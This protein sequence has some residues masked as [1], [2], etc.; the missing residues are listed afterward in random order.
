MN[1]KF[2]AKFGHIFIIC[3]SGKSAQ[4]MLAALKDRCA[5]VPKCTQAF[6]KRGPLHLPAGY[7]HL[8]RHTMRVLQGGWCPA[9]NAL[10]R[11]R[12]TAGAGMGMSHMLSW[13]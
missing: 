11:K 1:Q 10:H 2:E 8:D 12:G 6:S 9:R 7:V 13:P 4:E 5:S 3:A